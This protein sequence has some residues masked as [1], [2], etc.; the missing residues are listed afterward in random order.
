M[1]AAASADIPTLQGLY[2]PGLVSINPGAIT[3]ARIMTRSLPWEHPTTRAGAVSR[4][5]ASGAKGLE[6]VPVE[7]GHVTIRMIDPDSA[8]P[9]RNRNRNVLL[10][11]PID[12]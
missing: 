6:M 11:G 12:T 2:F 8:G 3:S 7:D 10:R 1:S 5:D 4:K 9:L